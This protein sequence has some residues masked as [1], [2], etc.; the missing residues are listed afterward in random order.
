M[1]TC[2]SLMEPA[3]IV[4]LAHFRKLPCMNHISHVGIIGEGQVLAFYNFKLVLL[5]PILSSAQNSL[6]LINNF[7][8]DSHTASLIKQEKVES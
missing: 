3:L 8:Y 5:V 2:I 4:T 6:T 7:Y 1:L